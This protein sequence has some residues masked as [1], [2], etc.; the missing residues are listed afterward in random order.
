MI[1][2]HVSLLVLRTKR[3]E[4]FDSG[5]L[6]GKMQMSLGT[7]VDVRLMLLFHCDGAITYGT[8]FSIN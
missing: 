7:A 5:L 3:P 6:G 8:G 2:L 4:T 1:L